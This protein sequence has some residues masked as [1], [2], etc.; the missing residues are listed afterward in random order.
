MCA[1]EQEGL[2]FGSIEIPYLSRGWEGLAIYRISIP[3]LGKEAARHLFAFTFK[4]Q[5]N[6]IWF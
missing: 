4:I 3:L 2:L 1:L 5:V 6:F